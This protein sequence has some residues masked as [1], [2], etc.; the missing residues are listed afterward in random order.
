[1]LTKST[2]LLLVRRSAIFVTLDC[3]LQ[4]TDDASSSLVHNPDSEQDIDIPG[5]GLYYGTADR[6]SLAPR[7]DA[8]EVDEL[9]DGMK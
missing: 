6:G 4:V 7:S 5:L 1:M 2:S 9:D 3:Q 8:D